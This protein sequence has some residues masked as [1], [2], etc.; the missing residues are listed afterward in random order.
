MTG[1][2]RS[3]YN[4]DHEFRSVLK[5]INSID[6]FIDIGANVGSYSDLLLNYNKRICS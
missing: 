3:Y 5:F 4:T 6:V 1:R 2:N